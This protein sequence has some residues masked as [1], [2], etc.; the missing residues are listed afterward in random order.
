MRPWKIDLTPHII[1]GEKVELRYEPEAYDFS[2]H[3]TEERPGDDMINRA[4]HMMRAYLILYRTPENLKPAP[5]LKVLDVLED[6]NAR[7]AKIETGDYLLEYDRKQLP[8]PS[9][10]CATL[11]GS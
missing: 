1:H 9:R 11:F 4:V 3:S 6:S 7:K 10:G 2:D 8:T 5:V